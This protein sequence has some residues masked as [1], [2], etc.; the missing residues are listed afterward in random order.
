[1]AIFSGI[2]VLQAGTNYCGVL[3]L[4]LALGR[5]A[6]AR[7]LPPKLVAILMSESIAVA[8]AIHFMLGAVL[9]DG[10]AAHIAGPSRAAANN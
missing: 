6:A 10:L 5:L 2:V 9:C 7:L 4:R 8:L 1:M 3:T